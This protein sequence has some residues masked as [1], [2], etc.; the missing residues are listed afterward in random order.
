MADT[1]T[2]P[3]VLSLPDPNSTDWRDKGLAVLDTLALPAKYLTHAL[4]GNDLASRINTDYELSGL[5]R[6]QDIVT[7]AGPG[8]T[9]WGISNE[10]AGAMAAPIDSWHGTPV[11]KFEPV[12]HNPF[13]VSGDFIF[14]HSSPQSMP[15]FASGYTGPREWDPT[16]STFGG[17]VVYLDNHGQWTNADSTMDRYRIQNVHDVG[18]HFDNAFVLSPNTLPELSSLMQDTPVNPTYAGNPNNYEAAKGAKWRG[19]DIVN[20][21][22]DKGYDGLVV[23]G[24]EKEREDLHDQ[25]LGPAQGRTGKPGLDGEENGPDFGD[26]TFPPGS[27]PDLEKVKDSY[28]QKLVDAGKTWNAEDI[29][30][31]LRWGEVHDLLLNKHGFS[32]EIGQDQVAAFKPENL[33][34]LRRVDNVNN[35]MSPV[36]LPESVGAVTGRNG[37]IITPVDHDPFTISTQTPTPTGGPSQ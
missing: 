4:T 13:G 29:G 33:Q 34:V 9:S 36:T 32:S 26:L 22:K 11:A 12:E 18:A 10:L 28:L 35:P 1:D 20:T 25:A 8:S 24:F 21:L 30:K 23:Q 19:T 17:D 5:Q 15:Q 6:P 37:E 16:D 7:Q 31:G 3:N 27:F 14:R 2:L